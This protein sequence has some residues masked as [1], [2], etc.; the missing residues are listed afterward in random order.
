MT[1]WRVWGKKLVNLNGVR[2]GQFLIAEGKI[3]FDKNCL[4]LIE[5]GAASQVVAWNIFSRR[6][7]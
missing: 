4:V 3:S 1:I 7:T 6:L 2:F 5:D